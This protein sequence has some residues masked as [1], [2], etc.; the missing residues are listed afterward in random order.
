MKRVLERTVGEDVSSNQL[1]RVGTVQS[2][3]PHRP[4][5]SPR[6]S[7]TGEGLRAG[8]GSEKNC[9]YFDRSRKG[10]SQAP[11]MIASEGVSLR[12][13]FLANQKRAA[14]KM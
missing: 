1:A 10:G 6:P 8:S 9:A 14:V 12:M 13:G 3:P 4:L 2:A 11:R 5:P 7:P